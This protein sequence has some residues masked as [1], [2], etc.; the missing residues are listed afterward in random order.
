MKKIALFSLIFVSSMLSANTI[1]QDTAASIQANDNPIQIISK[2]EIVGLWGMEVTSNKKC[3]EY[4]NFKSN[5]EVI[6]KSG[7]EWSNGLYEYHPALDA[8]SLAA[9]VLKIKYDNNEVDCSGQQID[10][11]DEVSQYFVQW[12][13]PNTINFCNN[14]KA[15]QCFATLYRVLP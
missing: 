7:Q 15:E 1:K 6:I 11:S 2:S 9:L 13:S 3:T 14:D 8:Q 10:Q 4:Y 12:K 5:Q